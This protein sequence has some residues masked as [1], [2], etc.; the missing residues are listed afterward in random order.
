[1]PR[2]LHRFGPKTYEFYEHL[3]VLLIKHYCKTSYRRIV[4]L[5]D[6]LGFRSPSKSALQYTAKKIPKTLWE[7]SLELTSGDQH[8]IIAIDGTGLSRTNPSYHYLMRIDGKMPKIPIKLSGCLDTR[9]K[10]WCS[11]R[12]RVLPAHD[13]Q[14]A[15]YLLA[16]TQANV[17]VA[18]KGYDA[19][20]LHS[21]CKERGMQTHIPIRNYGKSRH[22]RWTARRKAAL[23][24]RERTYHR[25]SLV[26]SGFSSIKRKYGASVS[27]KKARTIKA[28]IYGRLLCHNLLGINIRDL[29]QSRIILNIYIGLSAIF[30]QR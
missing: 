1:M 30:L 20:W 14:D 17:L 6:L 23:T 12:I 5:L 3:T 21:L 28:E 9:N 16:R 22:K 18:D 8:H 26:E 15:R 4:N 29:G 19:N 24:F 10:K 13:I 7:K 11:A 2:W 25:R 27:S